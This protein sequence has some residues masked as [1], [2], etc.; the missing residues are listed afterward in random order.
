MMLTVFGRATSS[1]VQA[2]IWALEELEVPYERLNYG[3][4]HAPLDTPEF[5][6]LNPHGL[7]P[8]LRDGDTVVWESAAILRYLGACHGGGAFWPADP[9]DRSQVDMWAEWAKRNVADAFTGP[10]FWRVVRTPRA[11]WDRPAIDAAV[12]VL[13]SNLAQADAQLAAH[14]YLCGS[15]MTLSD[16]T[17]GHLLYRYFDIEIERAPLPH[18]RRYADMLAGRPAYQRAVMVSYETLRDTI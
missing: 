2:V 8:V 12:K 7:I 14:P 16:I 13:N 1:N 17:L 5:L 11:R 15:E 3:E 6:A 10:V 4:G 18:L 9:R